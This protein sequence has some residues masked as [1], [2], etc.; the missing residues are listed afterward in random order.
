MNTFKRVLVDGLVGLIVALATAAAMAM[1]IAL[2]GKAAYASTDGIVPDYS[3]QTPVV[4][5]RAE[6]KR[7][8]GGQFTWLNSSPVPRG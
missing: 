4:F 1:G 5:M 7:K 3:E 2:A 6:D 8:F